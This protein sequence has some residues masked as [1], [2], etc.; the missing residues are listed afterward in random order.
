MPLQ[1]KFR[2]AITILF[3]ALLICLPAITEKPQFPK[4]YSDFSGSAGDIGVYPLSAKEL[5]WEKTYGGPGDDRAFSITPADNNGFLIVGSSSSFNMNDTAAYAVRID[6]SGNMV[7]NK[8]YFED[9]GSEFR[10]AQKTTDG[11]LLV[12][13]TFL[14]S[15]NEDAW[16]LKIDDQGN[17]LW[18]K[19]IGGDRFNKVFSVATAPGGFVLAGLTNSSKSGNSCA[20]LLKTDTEGNLLWNKTYQETQDSAF[21][22]I[23]VTTTGDYVIAGYSDS[24][25]NGNYDSL[26]TKTDANG[27]VIWNRTFGGLES[28]KA[29]ALAGSTSGYVIVGETHSNQEADAD[30]SVTKTDLDGRLVWNETYGGADFDVANAITPT[31]NGEYLVAGFTFSYGNGQRDFWFFEIDDLGNLVWSRTC[32]REGFEEAYAAVKIGDDEF[33]IG[34]WTNSIGKGSYDFYVIRAKIVTSGSGVDLGIIG[35]MI[36]A[37]SGMTAILIYGYLH[38]RAIRNKG[39]AGS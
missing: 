7:W 12:G 25:G 3:V 5:L 39:K 24:T 20:W 34:G 32:G 1:H 17:A 30:A 2:A 33:V 8:T 28:D 38:S 15:G 35:Y 18:N 10:N 19:T 26:L 36:L 16:I 23:L 31:G 21:R 27:T 29:Y 14:S 13:N 11:F 37:L 6:S 4:A 22:T 9:Y